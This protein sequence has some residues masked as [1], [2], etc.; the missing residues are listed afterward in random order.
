MPRHP[1][2]ATPEDRFRP[3]ISKL[4]KLGYRT[5]TIVLQWTLSMKPKEDYKSAYFFVVVVTFVDVRFVVVVECFVVVGTF[6]VVWLFV[7]VWT[8]DVVWLL[9]VVWTVDV[10]W[11]LVVVRAVVRLVVVVCFVDDVAATLTL[12]VGLM[13]ISRARRTLVV[14]TITGVVTTALVVDLRVDIVVALV[15][16]MDDVLA[17]LDLTDVGD[18]CVDGEVVDNNEMEVVCVDD[19]GVAA[20]ET[21]VADEG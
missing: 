7:V 10:V 5:N 18:A 13:G 11:L 21:T 8:V 4:T 20:L 9:V 17:V 12:G 15:V 6:E 1:N 14:A 16:F 19:I 3:F 2:Y